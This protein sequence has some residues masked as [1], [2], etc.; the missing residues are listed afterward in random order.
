MNLQIAKTRVLQNES[1]RIALARRI[2][3]NGICTRT[4]QEEVLAHTA[5]FLDG[6]IVVQ[7]GVQ[8]DLET[9]RNHMR[10]SKTRGV[11]AVSRTWLARNIMRAATSHLFIATAFFPAFIHSKA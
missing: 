3:G 1:I 11:I 10:V 9:R 5:D 6:C 2:V 8:H 7:I 4:I